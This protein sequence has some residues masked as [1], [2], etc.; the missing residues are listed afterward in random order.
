MLLYL[1]EVYTIKADSYN[2]TLV[3]TSPS[4]DEKGDQLKDDKGNLKWIINNKGYYSNLRNALEG[5]VDLN[6]RRSDADTAKDLIA[7]LNLLS[8][9]I[10][11]AI[12]QHTKGDK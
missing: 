4:V 10:N 1:D 5:Y 12:V 2:Y 11:K 3:E 9:S 6:L 7:E 8:Q